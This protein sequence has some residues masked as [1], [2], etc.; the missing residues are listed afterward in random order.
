MYEQVTDYQP[1]I[2]IGDA[3]QMDSIR[4]YDLFFSITMQQQSDGDANLPNAG[5]PME[6]GPQTP[7]QAGSSADSTPATEVQHPKSRL[8]IMHTP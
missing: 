2:H 6:Q 8:P 7:Q 1:D 4:G 5:L 3:E